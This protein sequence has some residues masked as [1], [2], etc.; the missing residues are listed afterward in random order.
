MKK[1]LRNWLE[2]VIGKQIAF[3][4]V[5]VGS[6]GGRKIYEVVFEDGTNKDYF[7]DFDHLE[8]EEY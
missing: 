3:S 1:Y 5:Y 2:E 4:P 6:K 8:I 7:I